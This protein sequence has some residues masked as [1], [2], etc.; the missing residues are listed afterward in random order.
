MAKKIISPTQVESAGNIPKI[1]REYFGLVNSGDKDISIAYMTS[2][3]GWEEPGQTPEFDEYTLLLK[4]EIIIETREK[5]FKI[6]EGQAY[7]AEKGEWVKYSTPEGAEYIA[8]CMPAFS[9]GTVH[10]DEN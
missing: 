2:P 1:I 8:V 7:K 9:Q 5:T 4:G 3:E 6:V 10:R